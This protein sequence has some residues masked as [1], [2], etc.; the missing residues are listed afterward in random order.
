MVSQEL[1]KAP[2]TTALLSQDCFLERKVGMTVHLEVGQ[3]GPKG[4]HCDSL[5]QQ[6]T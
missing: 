4:G 1:R 6:S 3:K 2:P 5:N